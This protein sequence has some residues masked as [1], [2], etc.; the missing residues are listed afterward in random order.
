MNEA[1]INKPIL[2]KEINQTM[3]IEGHQI[4][5]KNIKIFPSRIE[6]TAGDD[7]N[8]DSDDYVGLVLKDD[9]GNEYGL[10][11]AH[12]SEKNKMANYLIDTT[13]INSITII[14][15]TDFHNDTPIINYDKAITRN[16]R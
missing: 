13:T 6:L 11:D 7:L 1:Q 9:K 3:K 2:T 10:S 15:R 4:D 12:G 16:I 14:P 5:I 8:V